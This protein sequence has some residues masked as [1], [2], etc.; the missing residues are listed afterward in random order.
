MNKP[1]SV[2]GVAADNPAGKR[3]NLTRAR[4]QARRCAMQ[5]LY[6]W[7]LTQ[8]TFSEI[9]AQFIERDEYKSADGEYFTELLR[10]AIDQHQQ[11]E[12]RVGQYADRPWVQLDL[13]ERAILLLSTYELMNRMDVPY[14]VIVNEGVELAKQFGAT[15]SYKYINALLDRAAAGLRVA[16]R[17]H[18]DA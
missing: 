17:K 14:R 15:D 16:E 9:L 1:V 4:S 12:S 2:S 11:L 10:G 5:S 3:R 13:I 7:Q 8:Q 6:Q 18:R